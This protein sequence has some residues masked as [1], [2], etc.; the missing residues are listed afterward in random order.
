[1]TRKGSVPTPRS[2][3]GYATESDILQLLLGDFNAR[4][5]SSNGQNDRWAGVRV[6]FGV[7]DCT[8]VGERLLELCATNRLAIMN[9]CF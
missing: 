7:G 2:P 3:P 6:G 5:G 8:E 1:M 9:N 4:V